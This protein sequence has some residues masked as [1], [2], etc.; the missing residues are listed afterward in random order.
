V[1]GQSWIKLKERPS[2][3][4][5]LHI[6]IAHAGGMGDNLNVTAYCTALK[7]KFPLS[8]ITV[9]VSRFPEIFEGL[10]CID[11]VI[12]VTPP[13]S[14]EQYAEII[15]PEYDIFLEVRYATRVSFPSQRPKTPAMLEYKKET[16]KKFKKYAY[17]FHKFL[18]DIPAMERMKKPFWDIFYDS[19]CIQGSIDEMCIALKPE[20]F[21]ASEYY[22]GMR[23]VTVCNSSDNGL[24]TKGC[25]SHTWSE[26]IK[27]IKSL[28]LI[29][30]QTGIQSEPDLPGATRF[31]GSIFE[32]AA[33]VQ[34]A[35][36]NISIE[37]GIVHLAKAVG[38]DS[39]VLFGPTPIEIFG[40]RNNINIK[41]RTCGGCWWRSR[42]WMTVCTK[43]SQKVSPSYAPPCMTDIPVD[44]IK[45]SI[46]RLLE[47]HGVPIRPLKTA[48]SDSAVVASVHLK[49]RSVMA[50]VKGTPQEPFEVEALR[51][52]LDATGGYEHP[53]QIKRV[54]TIL[55][56]VGSGK[57]VLSVADGGY[58]GNLIKMQG[59]DV[60]VTDISEIRTIQCKEL[61]NLNSVQARA[62]KLPFP[63]A[64]FDVVIAAEIIEHVPKMS[65]VL[66]ELERVV[67][68]DGKIILTMPV[69]PDHDAYAEHLHSIRV[70]DIGGNMM[71]MSINKI[72]PHYD[73]YLKANRNT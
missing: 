47:K 12:K 19:A 1:P 20:H 13:Y 6:G 73:A 70:K 45:H 50:K 34:G 22:Q 10:T 38:T 4:R 37:G 56:M 40:Y 36:M 72:V 30:I 67:K 16:D 62:E 8:F 39:I 49:I 27:Y 48:M 66:A 54:H 41:G 11:R 35:L 25:H 58:I 51:L 33:L 63:D 61:L 31:F 43:T 65:V 53:L 15:K 60:T 57:K 32:T 42:D 7:R 55:N 52:K 26:V 64:S 5:V 21:K 69:H 46:H 44:K 18:S 59:N 68:K 14:V 24:Q 17:I 2:V 29:P 23:Y 3:N 28:G 71:V 9:I